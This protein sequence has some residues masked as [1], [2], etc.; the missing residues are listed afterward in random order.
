MARMLEANADALE[1]IRGKRVA[2]I[3][4]GNQGHAHALNLRDS[5]IDVC[6]GARP[7]RGFDA[8]AAAGFHPLGIEAAAECAD[9]VMLCTPDVPMRHLYRDQV[10]PYLR[11]G[12]TLLFAHGF[13]I[14]YGLIE[15]AEGVDVALVSPKGPGAWLRR[16]FESGKGLAALVAVHTDAT[17][18]AWNTALGYAW[19]IGSARVLMLETTFAEETESD[20]F[21]EQA[22]LCGGIPGLIKAAY[23]TLV[24]EGFQPEVAYFECLHEAKL[25]TDLLYERGL[26]GMRAAISDTAEWGGFAAEERIVGRE[27]RAGMRDLLREIRSGG[28]AREWIAEDAAGRMEL[29]RYRDEEAA[30]PIDAVGKELRQKMRLGQAR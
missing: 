27:T 4:Y 10:A 29:Q 23:E 9:V 13:N 21:G 3:G 26:A 17:G 19:G 12:D 2:V 24:A 6:V 1:A 15:A 5:G 8:A 14:R 11:P 25:I 28:F 22:V 30:H 16:E 20:L 7:G 18:T